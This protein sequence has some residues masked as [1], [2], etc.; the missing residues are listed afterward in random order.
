VGRF[1]ELGAD[2]GTIDQA[3]VSK[4][5]AVIGNAA[6]INWAPET[7]EDYENARSELKRRFAAWCADTGANVER[8]APE[9]P[10]HYKWGFLDGRLTHWT[11]NDLAEIY[12]EIYPA[13]VMVDEEEFGD[14]MTEAR[15]FLTF[16]AETELL[17]DDS[18]PIDVL[19][20]HLDLIEP[21]FRRNMAD[22]SRYSFGKRLWTTATAEGVPLDDP[23]AVEAFMADFNARTRSEREAVL[24][25]SPVVLPRPKAT[26]RIT[27]PGTRPRPKPSSAKRRKRRR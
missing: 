4:D 14:V 23:E 26:G 13:K 5:G 20:G 1:L 15:A 25:R 16:L 17:D 9:G 8:E 22:T 11:R 6:P 7:E 3:S 24:G 19:L 21:H 12:V 2:Q 18:E 10:I 27:A